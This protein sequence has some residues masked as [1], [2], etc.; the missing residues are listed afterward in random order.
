QRKLWKMRRDCNRTHPKPCSS[1]VIINIGCCTITGWPKRHL[2]A[3]AKCCQVTPRSYMLLQ[4]LRETRDIGTKVLPIG[5]GVSPSIRG[6]RR[7]SLK[8][9]LHMPHFDNSQ[10]RKSCT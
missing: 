2:H 7:Y 4:Q 3:S 9:H 1:R 6:I 8:W 5:N 10:E